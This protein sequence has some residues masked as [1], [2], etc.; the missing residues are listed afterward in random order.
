MLQYHIIFVCKYRKK[1]LENI[2]KNYKLQEEALAK[3]MVSLYETGEIDIVGLSSESVDKYKESPEFKT[4]LK[5]STYFFQV[6]GGRPTN[7]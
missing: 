3:R 5:A 7:K 2:E 6:N 4:L 1:L